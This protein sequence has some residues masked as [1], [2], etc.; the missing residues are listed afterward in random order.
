MK[1]HII[2]PGLESVE[3]DWHYS[4]VVRTRGLLLLSGVTGLSETGEISEDPATQFRAAFHYLGLYLAAAGADSSHIAEITSY[5]VDIRDH[6][7]VFNK[8][9]DEFLKRPFPAWT[10]VGV[11]ALIIPGTLLE[12]R[13]VA[14][15]PT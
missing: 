8:V 2:V 12:M 11:A 5:H 1:D 13:V 15:L 4:H 9:K 10:G 3:Q 6:I 7:D 14:D